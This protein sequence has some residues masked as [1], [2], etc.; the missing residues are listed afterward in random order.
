MVCHQ[1]NRHILWILSRPSD[2]DQTTTPKNEYHPYIYIYFRCHTTLRAFSNAT[3]KLVKGWGLASSHSVR[4]QNQ[5]TN[6]LPF[7]SC[8]QAGTTAVGLSTVPREG[9]WGKVKLTSKDIRN[10]RLLTLHVSQLDS[11][12]CHTTLRAFSNATVKLVKGWG[13]A[14]SHSVRCQNQKTNYLP[15]LSCPQAGTTAVGLSTVPT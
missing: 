12:R 9:G 4:C 11:F 7:L 8:P 1:F 3:V 13:L 5:K 14:S 15:F 6:Y 10:I 2:Q